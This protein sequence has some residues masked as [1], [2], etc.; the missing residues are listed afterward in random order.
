MIALRYGPALATRSP[1]KSDPALK[2][3]PVSSLEVGADQQEEESEMSAH[4]WGLVG[5]LLQCYNIL[6][7]V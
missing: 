6:T 3:S 2:R 5:I 4:G 1:A 7:A